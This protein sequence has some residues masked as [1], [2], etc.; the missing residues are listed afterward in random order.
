MRRGTHFA[1]AQLRS[2]SHGERGPAD[3]VQGVAKVTRARPSRRATQRVRPHAQGT[4]R[5][6][7]GSGDLPFGLP[8]KG[9]VCGVARACKAPA[10]LRTCA[11]HTA[12]LRGNVIP[13]HSVSRPCQRSMRA[14]ARMPPRKHP[15][16]GASTR[17]GNH[18]GLCCARPGEMQLRS[19][20]TRMSF[21]GPSAAK[22]R[23]VPRPCGCAC[24][25][26]LAG[27]AAELTAL[28]CSYVRT[29]TAS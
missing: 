26:V 12:P 29:T 27:C 3:T 23:V 13:L 14:P 25:G 5:R 28:L 4:Q 1:A 16:A 22:A 8:R 17:A 10:L 7:P 11:L 24:G 20:A 15:A 2:N 18:T 6:G 9:A 19:T 21:I